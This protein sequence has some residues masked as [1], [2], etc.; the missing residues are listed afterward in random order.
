MG[1]SIYCDFQERRSGIPEELA[2]TN[3][4]EE[5][6]MVVGDYRYRWIIFE[7]KPDYQF[8]QDRN[9][10][11]LYDQI[12]RLIE[13]C[14]KNGCIPCLI[15][16]CDDKVDL[17]T[18]TIIEKMLR[19]LA[20]D[21]WVIR[22]YGRSEGF[23]STL[24]VMLYYVDKIRKNKIL[25]GFLRPSGVRGKKDNQANF[26]CGFYRVDEVMAKRLLKRYGSVIG[27]IEN[28]TG[29]SDVKGIGKK[30]QERAIKLLWRRYP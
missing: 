6:K 10:K 14:G 23:N 29:W 12:G 16:E 20:K 18:Q 17:R 28:V 30:I 3:P 9:S 2:R 1:E 5:V 21:L 4:T 13:W 27:V 26:I 7:R 19:T 22:T 11:Q 15:S 24:S 8:I 25:P